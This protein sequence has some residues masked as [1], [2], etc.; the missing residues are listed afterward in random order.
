MRKTIAIIAIMIGAAA[1]HVQAQTYESMPRQPKETFSQKVKRG[2]KETFSLIQ[3][4]AH[5]TGVHQRWDTYIIPKVGVNLTQITSM[6]GNP[7]VTPSAGVTIE[8]FPLKNLAIDMDITFTHQ[9][10][11]N[12]DHTMTYT[13]ED[14]STYSETTRGYDY[15]L[16]YMNIAYLVRWYPNEKLP[17]SVYT[18]LHLARCYSAHAKYDGSKSNI[19]SRLHHGDM[20]I[21][22]G[23]SY[24]WKQWMGDLRFNFSPR[25]LPK[26]DQSKAIMG[27][28]RNMMLSLTV[29]YKIQ[30]F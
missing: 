27:E 17:L 6:G 23:V 13:R 19:R 2:V 18:G 30:V 24:E 21:P 14:G 8:M 3:Q 10:T 29:G 4:D 7:M 16:H 1:L 28:A 22:I 11:K 26:T 5:P 15:S 12:V 25:K 9:G 20:A